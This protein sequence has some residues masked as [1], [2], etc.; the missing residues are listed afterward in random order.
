LA[1]L[2]PLSGGWD[3]AA[4]AAIAKKHARA[5]TPMRAVVCIFVDYGQP[6][7]EQ[8][9]RASMRVAE[10]LGLIYH[11]IRTGDIAVDRQGVFP[12]RNARIITVI[13]GQAQ[14]LNVEHEAVYF[15]SR[16][17][18]RIFD[19]FKDSN[20]QW[21]HDMSKQLGVPIRTPLTCWPKALVRQVAI[22]AGI[23]PLNI[24]S[25]EGLHKTVRKP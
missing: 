21:A 11:P 22:K 25:T 4:C 24:Y 5:V 1:Y 3:S 2:V 23:N 20:A 9:K 14:M 18:L 16:C 8:E 7:A 15:G 19:H 17:P 13:L 12:M 10:D 6:Y